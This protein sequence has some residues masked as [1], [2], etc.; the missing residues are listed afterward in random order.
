MALCVGLGGGA[1][2]GK[3]SCIEGHCLI[4]SNQSKV[5]EE[6]DEKRARNDGGKMEDGKV[7]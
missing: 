6:E 4:S 2:R 7:D 3:K 5:V 1:V